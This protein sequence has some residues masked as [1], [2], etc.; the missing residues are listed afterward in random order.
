MEKFSDRINPQVKIGVDEGNKKRFEKN[1]L[2]WMIMES[3]LEICH[4]LNMICD[5]RLDLRL[6]EILCIYKMKYQEIDK[7]N[8]LTRIKSLPEDF[9]PP[10]SPSY[11]PS[12]I[13]MSKESPSSPVSIDIVIL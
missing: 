3:K 9:L 1:D 8:L 11:L 10:T 5:I 7:T 12:N 4:I 13:P 6:T 2:T